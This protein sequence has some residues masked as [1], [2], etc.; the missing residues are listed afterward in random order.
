MKINATL[1]KLIVEFLGVTLFLT[2]I[3]AAI[4]S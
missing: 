1:Q 2:A 4:S 3:G